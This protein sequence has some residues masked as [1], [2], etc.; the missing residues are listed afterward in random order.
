MN[1]GLK[2]NELI[3]KKKVRKIELAKYL[4]IA[5]NTLDDYLS[6]KTYMTTNTLEKV[7]K[8]FDTSIGYFFDDMQNGNITNAGSDNQVV[9]HGGTV[10][11]SECEKENAYLRALLE[12]KERTIKILMSK[13]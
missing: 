2:V 13:T 6:E 12:E 3:E 7:A 9:S 1:I 11:V 8:F 4:D 5:R 10:A